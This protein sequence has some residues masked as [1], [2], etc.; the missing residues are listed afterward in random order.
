MIMTS[1]I[2]NAKLDDKYPAT[3]SKPILTGILRN[4][5]KFE[6]VIITDDLAMGALIKNYPFEEILEKS[7]NAG[8]NLLC[9]S[10]NGETYDPNIA[11]KAVDIIFNLVKAG[12]IQR[13]TIDN[14]YNR[15]L[16]LKENL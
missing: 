13:E 14:S 7:I 2:F 3:M 5:L 9:L 11:S 8:A 16:K 10:N 4:K 1:H 6:G 12:K 15:I